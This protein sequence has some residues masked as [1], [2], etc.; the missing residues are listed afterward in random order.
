MEITFLHADL[1][2]LLGHLFGE[3][4]FG[5]AQGFGDHHRHVIGAADHDGADGGI[6]VDGLAG[7]KAQLGGVLGRGMP[8]HR[9]LG[10]HG[11]LA[12]L[13]RVEQQIQGHHLGQRSGVALG[14]LVAGVKHLAGGSIH[15]Q[16]SVFLGVCG[17][18]QHLDQPA[19]AMT[20]RE[21]Q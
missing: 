17:A 12:R 9:H 15:D 13:Q 3:M 5:A 18:R 14:G 1:A 10:L 19:A 16:S 11:D 21:M 6:H 8:A 20:E 2:G 4:R 7:T